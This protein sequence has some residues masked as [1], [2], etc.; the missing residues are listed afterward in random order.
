M[1]CWQHVVVLFVVAH[2]LDVLLGDVYVLEALRVVG[3]VWGSEVEVEG[4]M[5]D[6]WIGFE[7]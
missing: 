1:A 2:V 7:W 6:E 5:T 3:G 4:D